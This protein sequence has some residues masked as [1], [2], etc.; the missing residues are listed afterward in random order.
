MAVS[1]VL[2]TPR[3]VLRQVE[4]SDLDYVARLLGDPVVM[5]YWPRPMTREDSAD[6]IR[7]Q[8]ERYARDGFGYWQVLERATG[9]PVG[10]AG[11]MMTEVD[12]DHEPGLGYIFQSDAWGR[13]LAT[14]AAAG[15][16][17]WAFARHS[18]PR[19]TCLVRPENVPSLRVAARLGMIP[20]R[21]V[22]FSG[23]PHLLWEMRRERWQPR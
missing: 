4:L 22:D 21:H 12:G 15:T 11:L 8:N 20:A 2:E 6:W 7:R 5:R 14:E 19:V 17:D 18:F 13:G 3:L 1:S 16:L 23:L 10:Q 9:R